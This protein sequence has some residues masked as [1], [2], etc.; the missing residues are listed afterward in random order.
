MTY[1][2]PVVEFFLSKHL[3]EFKHISRDARS[4][5]ETRNPI[6]AA[7]LNLAARSRDLLA[8]TEESDRPVR[9]VREAVSLLRLP[10]VPLRLAGKAVRAGRARARASWVKTEH[11]ERAAD[12]ARDVRARALDE[13]RTRT[14]GA[15]GVDEH[16]ATTLGGCGQEPQCNR[17]LAPVRGVRQIKG[18]EQTSALLAIEARRPVYLRGRFKL[19]PA[20][21]AFRKH[22][23]K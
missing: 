4:A 9:N 21:S 20:P 7:D 17:S 19:P 2:T 15:A 1:E 11:V 22:Y 12:D 23:P 10:N 13:V 3:R 18:Q 16:C 14:A 8:R 6:F 5:H